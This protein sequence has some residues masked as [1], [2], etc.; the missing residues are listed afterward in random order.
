MSR[1]RVKICGIKTLQ[2]ALAI[3]ELGADA[4]GFVF[5]EKSPRYITVESAAEIIKKLP[6][7]ITCVGLFVNATPDYV[8]N[9]FH[10]ARLDLLQ[11]HGNESVDYCQ[12]INLP[13]IKAVRIVE[14]GQVEKA[15]IDYPLAKGLLVDAYKAGVPG[16]TGET[17]DWAL[18]PSY[19]TKP[20]ILAGGLN[21][22][23]IVS[24]I[25]CIS[26]F[27]VDVSGGV[28]CEKGKKDL[29]KVANFLQE[30]R[31]LEFVQ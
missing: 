20:I 1:T 11:F 10:Y 24:A 18:L 14:S 30:V 9:V 22:Q 15:A 19:C 21:C 13:Y 12:S 28:E 29:I 5:Y 3:C 26:P 6:P 7:F 25:N 2:D 8:K 31:K 27:A 23:N 16:G 17:F 4:L